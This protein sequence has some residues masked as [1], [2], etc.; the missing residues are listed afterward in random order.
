[1]GRVSN[2]TNL[3]VALLNEKAVAR[4]LL[5]SHTKPENER[6]QNAGMNWVLNTLDQI[7]Q[8]EIV[9]K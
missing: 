8:E 6:L 9:K 4:R 7:I 5:L 3:I 1:M 2:E